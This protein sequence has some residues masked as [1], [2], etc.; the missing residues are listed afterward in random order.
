MPQDC[1]DVTK[2]LILKGFPFPFGI[3]M[4]DGGF[5]FA[6]PSKQAN[7][8]ILCLYNR[9]TNQLVAEIP[10]SPNENKTGN[11]WH[12]LLHH[13]PDNLSYAYKIQSTGERSSKNKSTNWLN[14]PIND[15]YA[16]SMA[17][18]TIWGKRN[19]L[20]AKYKTGYLPS[21]NVSIAEAFDW[22]ND[23][24]PCIPLN[25]L[26]IYEMHVRGFTQDASSGVKQPGT[27]MGIIEK[28][29]YLLELGV[30]ALEL[31]PLQE[32]NELEYR[33]MHPGVKQPLFNY[34]GYS[35]VNFFSPM[36]RYAATDQPGAAIN[37][38]K[39]MVKELHRNKIEVI[40][41]VVFNHTAEGGINGTVLSFKSIDNA[42]FYMVDNHGNYS[43]Y[44]GCGNTLNANQPFVLEF[45]IACLR[46][47]VVEMHVDGFRFD[48]A[49]ALT[50]DTNGLPMRK[51]P[52]I[53][54][55]TADPLLANIKL[56]AE[57]WD[58]SGLYQVG[59]FAP[60]TK[61][62]SEWNGKYRDCVRNFIKGTAGACGD[63]AMRISG[64]E[65]L[66]HS[67][68]PS[69]SIN[70]ITAHDGFTLRDLVSYNEKHNL[71]NGENNHDG[72]NENISWNCG[73]E[74]KTTNQ[75]ILALRERQMRN[76]HLA[77][78]V[79]QGVPM[80]L[81]GDEYGH[82]KNGNNNTWCQDGP[83]NW[84][85]WGKLENEKEFYRFY[86]A[87][88]HFRKNQPLLQRTTFLT[89]KDVDWHGLVPLKAD[90]SG[91]S[92]FVA[93]SLKDHLYNRDLYIAFNTYDDAV[94]VHLPSPPSTKQ[95]HLVV[96]TAN[97]SPTDI[98]EN[99]TGPIFSE[100]VYKMSSH[101]AILLEAG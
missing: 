2:L 96:N 19:D 26:I 90:W 82:T 91:S 61:R 57:A 86:R 38:F 4:Q 72:L 35:T 39:T 98:Y 59:A 13:L 28:I 88:I 55:I 44:S 51:S 50:R 52:L 76:F 85:L 5:N 70:F 75:K 89:N 24:P 84:F 73:I 22:E 15:P 17:T 60:E 32:F 43:N 20:P 93:F 63:F 78:M 18:T 12:I 11:V 77:L 3:S 45:I 9:T 83:I 95:W 69:N 49:S 99:H 80:L 64:S 36:N 31:M 71:D 27:F 53:A 34:W 8:V 21:A 30:N 101:S 1:L 7:A 74:G 79:S 56:I 25:E 10:L 81:M 23:V 41:D 6:L 87:L 94:T 100:G 47:W 65:D 67:R 42:V 14:I 29:P 40:L 66:Y 37:E 62:W 48:L 58:A 97:I 33:Y 92:R 16:K 54:A 68:T 46:Y